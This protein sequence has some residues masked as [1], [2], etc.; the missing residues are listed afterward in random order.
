MPLEVIRADYADR[1]HA[2]A[3]VGL[4][5]AYAQDPMG[6]GRPLPAH[7]HER[8]VPGLAATPGALTLLALEGAAFVGLVNAFAGYSTFIAR[9][10]LNLHDVFVRPDHRG[11]GIA[12]R[13]LQAAEAVARD[14][15]CGKLTLE[16]LSG[17]TAAQQLY[18][19]LGYAPYALDE[20]AG[21]AR[22]WQ[23]PPDA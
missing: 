3:I 14:R 16:V 6:G 12:R 7:V 1:R 22:F 2:A 20:A 18:R 5:D 19:A 11:R 8:L 4:L 17:N 9:P 23:K 10:L 21:D 15:G 13:L